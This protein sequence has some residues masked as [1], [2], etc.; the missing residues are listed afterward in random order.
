MCSSDLSQAGSRSIIVYVEVP[1]PDGALKGGMFAKG[2]LTLTRRDA[3]TAVPISALREERGE[4][5]VYAIENNRLARIP[6][7]T[8]TRHEDEAWAEITASDNSR[9]KPGIKVVKSNLGALNSGVEVKVTDGK[10]APAAVPVA[11]APATAP[12]AAAAIP[13]AAAA[14]ASIAPGSTTPSAAK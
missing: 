1:N 10:S 14:P 11:A 7:K 9:I 6:V 2:G 3:V 8:G 4:T 5:V 13:P 12:T